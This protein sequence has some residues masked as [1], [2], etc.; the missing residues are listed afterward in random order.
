MPDMIVTFAIDPQIVT[1]D[2]VVAQ[3]VYYAFCRRAS[4]MC[5]SM[6]R[7]ES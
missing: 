3:T 7:D 6:R 1:A 5:S 4:L 2:S